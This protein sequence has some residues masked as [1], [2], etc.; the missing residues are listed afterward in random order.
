M[1]TPPPKRLSE[2]CTK[3]GGYVFGAKDLFGDPA[4]LVRASQTS[5]SPGIVYVAMNYRLGAFCFLGGPSL[6]ANA[7]LHDQRLALEWVQQ[8]IA[9]FGGDPS[10]VTIL[11]ESAG[12]GSIFHQITAFGGLLPVAFQQ[13][14]SQSEAWFPRPGNEQQEE[15]FNDFLNSTE[16][17]YA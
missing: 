8:H 3:G 14:V 16:C 10:R 9:Q 15:V 12:G 7:G 11:G 13:A 4:G 2:I 5:G 6:Q 1:L 17:Q